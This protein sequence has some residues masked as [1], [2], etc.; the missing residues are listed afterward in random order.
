MVESHDRLDRIENKVD[1]LQ[2]Q[3]YLNHLELLGRLSDQTERYHEIDKTVQK[4][5]QHFT[6][7]YKTVFW[8]F[9]GS[10]T[11]CLAALTQIKDIFKH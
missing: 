1:E 2:E 8:V 7:I 11:A 5:E 3:I 6:G 9:G 4:H 10:V